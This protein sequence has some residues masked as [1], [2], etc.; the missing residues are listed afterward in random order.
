[1]GFKAVRVNSRLETVHVNFWWSLSGWTWCCGWDFVGLWEAG[2]VCAVLVRCR[3]GGR[4]LSL[5]LCQTFSVDAVDERMTSV[6]SLF[7]ALVFSLV[8]FATGSCLGLAV[9]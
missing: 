9:S 5:L 6:A 1:M 8:A 7:H 2:S 4:F 3:V